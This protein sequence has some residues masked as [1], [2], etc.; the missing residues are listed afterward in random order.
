VSGFDL[1]AGLHNIEF[2]RHAFFDFACCKTSYYVNQLWVVGHICALMPPVGFRCRVCPVGFVE[3]P[4]VGK[5]LTAWEKKDLTNPN[6]QHTVSQSNILEI[7]DCN[8]Y[9]NIKRGIYP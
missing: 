1:G 6:L 5:C 8:D 3:N 4:T 7:S 9:G 2:L